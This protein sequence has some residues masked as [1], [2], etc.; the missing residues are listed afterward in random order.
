MEKKLVVYVARRFDMKIRNN[1]ITDLNRGDVL[2]FL[3][4]D[5]PGHAREISEKYSEKRRTFFRKSRLLLNSGVSGHLPKLGWSLVISP[6]RKRPGI[7]RTKT[8]SRHGFH[9]FEPVLDAAKVKCTSHAQAMHKSFD[10][11]RHFACDFAQR[12]HSLEWGEI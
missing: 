4:W 9:R 1:I 11:V 5:M 8:R 3:I 12:F 7:C 10:G 6:T 2:F